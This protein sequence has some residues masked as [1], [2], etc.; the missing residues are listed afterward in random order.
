MRESPGETFASDILA[1]AKD[2]QATKAGAT[3]GG[4]AA[5]AEP[6]PKEAFVAKIGDPGCDVGYYNWSSHGR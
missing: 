2:G 3:I 4:P 1:T 5:A 6:R